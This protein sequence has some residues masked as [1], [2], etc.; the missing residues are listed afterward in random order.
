[1]KTIYADGGYRGELVENVKKKLGYDMRI[2]LRPDKAND[3]EPLPKRRIAE[4]SFAWIG[5]FRRWLKTMKER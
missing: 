3:F 2:T 1:M 5:D 4:R